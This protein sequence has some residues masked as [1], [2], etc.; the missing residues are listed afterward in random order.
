MNKGLYIKSLFVNIPGRESASIEF[1]QGL[2]LITGPSNTGKSWIPDCINYA[3]GAEETRIEVPDK[4]EI[5]LVV[6][7]SSGDV[8]LRRIIGESKINISTS[9]NDIDSGDYSCAKNAKNPIGPALL[10]LIG[11]DDECM[12][13]RNSRFDRQRLTIRTFLYLCIAEQTPIQ[14]MSSILLPEQKVQWPA[15]LSA[16]LFL[17]T[18]NNFSEEDPKETKQIK[19]ARRQAVIEFIRHQMAEL[20]TQQAELTERKKQLPEETAAIQAKI[21]NLTGLVAATEEQ[22][23]SAL[24]ESQS[25]FKDIYTVNKQLTECS[26]LHNRYTELNSQ[27]ASDIKRLTFIVEGEINENQCVPPDIC[28]FCGAPTQKHEHP[29]YIHAAQIELNKII[30]QQKDLSAADADVIKESHDLHEK[31]FKLK[32]DR[33]KIDDSISEELRPKVESLRRSLEHYRAAIEVDSEA[34]M[35]DRYKQNMVRSLE[36]YQVPIAKETVSFDPR[37][38]LA[39]NIQHDL[40]IMLDHIF[41]ECHFDG[42]SSV[43]FDLKK[44]DL[45]VNGH[46]KKSFGQGFRTFMNTLLL[47]TI[48]DYLSSDKCAYSPGFLIIDSP[49]MSLKEVNDAASDNMKTSLFKYLLSHQDGYQKIIIENTPPHLDYSGINHIHFT[50]TSEDRYGF[51]P[52][53]TNSDVIITE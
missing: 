45:V 51:I 26:L 13:I 36:F 40:D 3:L 52:G 30:S 47:L 19:E 18:G 25:L 16:L 22:I 44:Y 33:K 37:N 5:V 23:K 53:K 35:L 32:E 8:T 17:I 15:A 27:Y 2:N 29:I 42:Y 49:I 10:P 14:K 46:P 48:H 6:S 4:T 28:P 24:D 50:G 34:V 7:T 39:G 20:H 1:S 31:L 11:I 43:Y 9:R 41:K 21:Q 38:H 12:I